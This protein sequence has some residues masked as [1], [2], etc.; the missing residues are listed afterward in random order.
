M[1]II[2]DNVFCDYC[3]KSNSFEGFNQNEFNKLY[4]NLKENENILKE[5]IIIEN[6][7]FA[8][9]GM[10]AHGYIGVLEILESLNLLKNISF[11]C[12]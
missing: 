3:L 4:D 10:K 9:C 2:K 6:I 8:G 1:T 12:M 5:K 7:S 11:L